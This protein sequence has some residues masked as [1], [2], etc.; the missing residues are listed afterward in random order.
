MPD[1]KSDQDVTENDDDEDVDLKVEISNLSN[2]ES[3]AKVD[4][5]TDED[6]QGYDEISVNEN[7]D[8]LDFVEDEDTHDEVCS[9]K[10]IKVYEND[11]KTIQTTR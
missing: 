1:D 6:V 3:V 7:D 5:N 4:G 8:Q 2:E 9:Y 10:E 11:D